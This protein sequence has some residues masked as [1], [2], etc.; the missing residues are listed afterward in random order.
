MVLH[1]IHPDHYRLAGSL[2]IGQGYIKGRTDMQN[3]LENL[4]KCLYRNMMEIKKGS[5]SCIF[6]GQGYYLDLREQTSN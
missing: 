3:D 1:Q 2:Y 6:G 5:P 4:E